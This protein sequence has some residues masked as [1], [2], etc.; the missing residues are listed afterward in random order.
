MTTP[1]GRE[2][3]PSTEAQFS[4]A[5]RT[6]LVTGSTTGL[7]LAIAKSLGTAGAKV[8]L[9]YFNNQ[10]RG[11][12]ALAEYRATGAEGH[13][14]RGSVIEASGVRRIVEEVEASLGGID[15]LVGER[16]AGPAAPSHRGV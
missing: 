2:E 5:G 1:D 15:I 11:E 6:A 13:L 4:L 14:V 9:N 10:S 16:D 8:A 12:A 3:Q 7:G